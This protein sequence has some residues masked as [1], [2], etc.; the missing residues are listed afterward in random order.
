MDRKELK[1]MKKFICIILAVISIFAFTACSSQTQTSQQSSEKSPE[2]NSVPTPQTSH[3][4]LVVFFSATGSTKRAAQFI[5]GEANADLFEIA[6]KQPYSA[7]DL[8]YNDKSSRVWLE[9]DDD[10]LRKV[11][12]EKTTPDSWSEYDTVFIGYP[13]WWG[14]ASWVVSSFVQSNDFTGKTVIPF[15][16]SASSALGNSAK[17]LAASST[18]GTWLDGIRFSSSEDESTVKEWAKQTLQEINK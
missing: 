7:N 13:I 10:S 14:E 11:D 3:K 4:A 1:Q 2:S 6:P 15:C 18:G 17:D 8:N 12:L 5:A 9:H 16:T